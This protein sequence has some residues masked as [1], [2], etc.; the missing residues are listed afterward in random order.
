MVSFNELQYWTGYTHSSVLPNSVKGQLQHCSQ[1]VDLIAAW[2]EAMQGTDIVTGYNISNFDLWFIYK[3][4][5]HHKCLHVLKRLHKVE[6]PGPM[7]LIEMR[8]ESGGMGIHEYR[9]FCPVGMVMMDMYT[10]MRKEHKDLDNYK[11]DHVAKVYLGEGKLPMPVSELFAKLRGSSSDLIDVIEYCIQDVD[12]PLR[13]MTKLNKVNIKMQTSNICMVT[14]VDVLMRGEQIRA[15]CLLVN[16]CWQASM[17]IE[18]YL[19]HYFNQDTSYTGAT[20]LQP[21][22]GY[23]TEPVVALDFASLYPSIMISNN[24]CFSTLLTTTQTLNPHA[25]AEHGIKTK[26]FN[27]MDSKSGAA[28]TYEFVQSQRG[29]VPSILADLWEER[30]KVRTMQKSEVD[31]FKRQVQDGQQLSIKLTMNSIY[32]FFGV[33]ED[34]AMLACHPIAKCITFMGR[35]LIQDTKEYVMREFG[36][37]VVYGDTDSVFIIFPMD[38]DRS[39][40]TTFAMAENVAT[41]CNTYL[42]DK[43]CY[44]KG[45]VELEF[46]KVFCPFLLFTKKRYAA[47]C[48]E[49][50]DKAKEKLDIKG[51]SVVRRDWCALV[52]ATGMQALRAILIDKDVDCAKRLLLGAMESCVA[53]SATIDDLVLSKTIRD[54]YAGSEPAHKL[55]A[56][57]MNANGHNVLP[58]ERVHYVMVVPQTSKQAQAECAEHPDIIRRDGLDI[59][60]VWY[61]AKQLTKPFCEYMSLVDNTFEDTWMQRVKLLLQ[62]SKKHLHLKDLHIAGIQQ[63]TTFFT[64][65]TKLIADAHGSSPDMLID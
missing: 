45:V 27:W 53:K 28:Q 17:V 9:Y 21:I 60:Y 35:S 33:P 29:I 7:K 51:L 13:L 31:E 49:S 40:H 41:S 2:V 37:T 58:G 12:L 44:W 64:P 10:L 1:E 62:E 46:E 36:A 48:W 47:L 5:V 24:I 14:V 50:A 23:Y 25:V 52:R 57:K 4:C 6:Q 30:R 55:V 54:S 8:K 11:L 18:D 61:I 38:S 22:R 56:N 34:K 65:R 15:K 39:M 59:D 26:C 16:R 43:H 3:R 32:G 42:N 63:I 20:V 19:T